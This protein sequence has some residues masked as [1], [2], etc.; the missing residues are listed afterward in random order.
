MASE[1]LARRRHRKSMAE[2]NVVPYIDVML[3][4]LIIFMVTAP[5]LQQGVEVQLPKASAKVVSQDQTVPVIVSVDGEGRYFLSFEEYK[6]EP[7]DA[8]RLQTLVAAILAHKP[9][10]QV[11]VNG[12]RSA[13]YGEVVQAMALLQASGVPQVGLLTESPE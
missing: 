8:N 6:N 13:S 12:D 3:V 7:V 9:G 10:I 1:T 11:L 4:L 2:I 5:L